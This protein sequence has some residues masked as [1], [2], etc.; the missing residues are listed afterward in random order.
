VFLNCLVGTVGIP[1]YDTVLIIDNLVQPI[2]D[3][4][5]KTRDVAGTADE[6]RIH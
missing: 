2:F 1:D 3:F 4:G 6:Y 5:W